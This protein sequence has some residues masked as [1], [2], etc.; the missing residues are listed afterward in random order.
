MDVQFSDI[1]TT[2]STMLTAFVAV[3]VTSEVNKT[4]I[5]NLKETIKNLELKLDALKIESTFTQ[6]L[7]RLKYV[8]DKLGIKQEDDDK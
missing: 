5:T 1:L 3:K 4:E 8:E 2:L 7:L 6:L